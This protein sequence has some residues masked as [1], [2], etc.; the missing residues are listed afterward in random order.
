MFNVAV[1][2]APMFIVEEPGTPDTVYV[3]VVFGVPVKVTV[4]E[5]PEQTGLAPVTLMLAVGAGNI[6]MIISSVT[7]AHVPEGSTVEIVMV[8]E[9]PLITEAG[10]VYVPVKLFPPLENEPP[11]TELDQ[12]H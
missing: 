4:E 7:A 8:T 1:P 3:T 12:S 6:V 2:P 10:I 11:A 9:P 5:L